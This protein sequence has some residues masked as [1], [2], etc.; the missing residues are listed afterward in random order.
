MLKYSGSV[1]HF[2]HLLTLYCERAVFCVLVFVSHHVVLSLISRGPSKT[3]DM[4][5]PIAMD[6]IVLKVHRELHIVCSVGDNR[7]FL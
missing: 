1:H 5:R 3:S 6:G 4:V 7:I 2:S